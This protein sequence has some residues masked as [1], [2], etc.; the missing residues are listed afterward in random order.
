M[1]KTLTDTEI[2]KS[3]QNDIANEI[4]KKKKMQDMQ[5]QVLSLPYPQ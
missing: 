1:A 2:R 4:Y 5:M 3:I